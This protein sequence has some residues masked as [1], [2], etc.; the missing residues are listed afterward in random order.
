MRSAFPMLKEN[1]SLGFFRGGGE[2]E[3]GANGSA[4]W[5]RGREEHSPLSPSGAS[6]RRKIAIILRGGGEKEASSFLK[7]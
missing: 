2:K 5:G 4:L 3:K 7:I 1:K 6:G